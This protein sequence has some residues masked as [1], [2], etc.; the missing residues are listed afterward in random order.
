MTTAHLDLPD[1][2]PLVA[3]IS[4]NAD[5]LVPVT[6]QDTATG[7]I[8]MQAWASAEAIRATARTGRATFWSR[9][10]R[11]LWEKGATSGHAMHV[12]ELRLDCDG[13]AVLYLVVPEGPSCHTGRPSC[14]F[15]RLEGHGL[16]EDDGP[17]G[18]ASAILTRLA[19]VIAARKAAMADPAA[20]KSYVASL[21]TRGW[22]KIN[23]KILEE[24]REVTEALPSGDRPHA[25]HEAADVLFHLMVGLEAA[26]V[27]VDDVFTELARRFGTSGLTEKANRTKT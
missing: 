3:A 1:P 2:E 18:P 21:L 7:V 10:R 23:E 8:R 26:G 15:R 5:G 25:A 20:E 11:A 13:D 4:F 14:F 9:S 17:S 16:T 22:P 6:A 27:P 24:A 19:G 12:R